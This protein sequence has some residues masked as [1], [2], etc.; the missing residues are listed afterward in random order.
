MDES[1]QHFE[2]DFAI[3]FAGEDRLVAEPLARLLVDKGAIVF[4]DKFY[5]SRLLG[6]KLGREFGQIYGPA[7]RFV[8]PII[9]QHYVRKD[10]TDYEFWIAKEEQK[11]R[12]YEF[13]L[14]L[15]LDNTPV[16]GLPR[17][18]GFVDLREETIISAA[19]VLMEKLTA[20]FPKRMRKLPEMWVATLG[21][22]V[23][24]VLENWSLP[25]SIPREYAHLCD[26]LEEDLQERL[27]K[28]PIKDFDLPEASHRNGEALS[29]RI[30]FHWSPS[31]DPLDFGNLQWWEVLQILPFEEVYPGQ[32]G[33][34]F[35]IAF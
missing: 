11:R 13:I 9:S 1:G 28:A 4:Y 19:E 15:R 16:L 5:K 2:F 23:D 7:S 18:A 33:T 20:H 10:Y 32:D 31:D 30:T 24:E 3:S 35:P 6:K 34:A 8:V 22:V 17:D 12:N 25:A 26:W 29:V 21:L 27:H 14:P